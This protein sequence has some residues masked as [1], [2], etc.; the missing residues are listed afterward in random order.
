MLGVVAS[1]VNLAFQIPLRS[2]LFL[3]TLSFF[4]ANRY[5]SLQQVPFTPSQSLIKVKCTAG[6]KPNLASWVSVAIARLELQKWSN[7]LKNRTVSQLKSRLVRQ[8]LATVQ[9]LVLKIVFTCGDLTL[10]A[11]SVLETKKLTGCPR[12]SALTQRDHIWTV[13]NQLLAAIMA[14]SVLMWMELPFLGARDSL[15]T[16]VRQWALC[17]REYWKI[18]VSVF[19]QRYLQV[20]MELFSM[21][22]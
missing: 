7:S 5:P 15:A 6:A 18:Q 19:S 14:P 21:P 8:A 13:S 22:Q 11:R 2:P 1:K 10:M 9:H 16:Q 12:K 17:P 4:T 20:A 3:A